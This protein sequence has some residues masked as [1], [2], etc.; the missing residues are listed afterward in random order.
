VSVCIESLTHSLSHQSKGFGEGCCPCCDKPFGGKEEKKA[1]KSRLNELFADDSE[2]MVANQE[3][4]RTKVFLHEV[5]RSIQSY[6]TDLRDFSRANK[7]VESLEAEMAKLRVESD[8]A[9]NQVND[10]KAVVDEL[11]SEVNELRELLDSSKRWNEDANRIAS[12]RMKI[13]EKR[14]ALGVNTQYHDRDLRT[15]EAEVSRLSDEKDSISNRINELNKEMNLLNKNLHA[16]AEI[17]SVSQDV[18]DSNLVSRLILRAC[19]VSRRQR[20][21]RPWPRIKKLHSKSRR[22]TTIKGTN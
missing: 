3:A 2:L 15:V 7:E 14:Y 5:R 1:F 4:K 21:S 16:Q 20:R 18:A 13:G 12:K 6:I 19:V 11:Q 9:H 22:R 17:V 10:Q 8:V